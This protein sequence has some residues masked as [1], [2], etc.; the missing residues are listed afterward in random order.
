MSS[1]TPTPS[2]KPSQADKLQEARTKVRSLT[3]Q[4]LNPGLSLP[5]AAL[6]RTLERSARAEVAL[7]QKALQY[8]QQNG[9]TPDLEQQESLAQG[10]PGDSLP[11]QIPP[12][13]AMKPGS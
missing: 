5:T 13:P 9:L 11:D 10:K 2:Q 12:S 7:R 1:S 3:V 4:S 8:A 6:V